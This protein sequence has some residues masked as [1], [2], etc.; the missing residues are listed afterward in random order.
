M[1]AITSDGGLHLA[2]CVIADAAAWIHELA[3]EEQEVLTMVATSGTQA[4]SATHVATTTII[5]IS[6]ITFEPDSEEVATNEV[7]ELVLHIVNA[8]QR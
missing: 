7:V 2:C 1:S 3:C 6:V 5:T 4:E 8:E